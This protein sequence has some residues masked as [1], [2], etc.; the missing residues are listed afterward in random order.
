MRNLV[1]RVA[2]IASAMFLLGACGDATDPASLIDGAA[3]APWFVF[4]APPAPMT[5]LEGT[6]EG[7]CLPRTGP[8]GTR[9]SQWRIAYFRDDYYAASAYYADEGCTK[10]EPT[11]AWYEYGKFTIGGAATA[12]SGA[13]NIDYLQRA[14]NGQTEH[15]YDAMLN[16]MGTCSGVTFNDLFLTNM[17]GVQCGGSRWATDGSTLLGIFKLDTS[18]VPATLALGEIAGLGQVGAATRP[19][20]LRNDRYQIR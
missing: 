18:V 9:S 1:G 16:A 20:T 12:P 8:P 15:G 4:D 5:A 3:D 19:T 14:V 2:V 7:D 11:L 17:S 10:L 6:W 13:T